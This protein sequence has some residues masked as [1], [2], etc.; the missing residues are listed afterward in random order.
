VLGFAATERVASILMVRESNGVHLGMIAVRP[1][2][3]GRG[4]GSALLRE[5]ERITSAERL[6]A[7][8]R[9]SVIA[10]R[11]ELIA[12]YARRGFRATGEHAPFPYGEARFGVPRRPD[13]YFLTLAKPVA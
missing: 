8:L 4:T 13:L 9:M 2:R 12:W 6:G 10:Q 3:Q 7:S 5:A 1:D 11:S